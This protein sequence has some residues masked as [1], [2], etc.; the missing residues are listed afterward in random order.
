MTTHTRTEFIVQGRS[1]V[2]RKTQVH[3]DGWIHLRNSGSLE[4]ARAFIE[5]DEGAMPPGVWEH[6]IISRTTTTTD[7]EEVR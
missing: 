5:E 7:W 6:R 1:D 3:A 4:E 2:T